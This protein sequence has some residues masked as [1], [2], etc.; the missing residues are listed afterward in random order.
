MAAAPAAAG[1]DLGAAVTTAIGSIGDSGGIATHLAAR[2]SVLADA[3]NERDSTGQ[4]VYPNGFGAAFG[5]AEVGAPELAAAD[6]LVVGK[7]KVWLVTRNDFQVDFSKDF[8]F[9]RDAVAVR[10][11]GRFAVAAPDLPKGLRKLS[12]TEPNG[13]RTSSPARSGKSA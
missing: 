7:A 13:A 12:V 9:D 11:R 3:R 8:A 6:I 4:M 1:A 10:I 2:P 5:L